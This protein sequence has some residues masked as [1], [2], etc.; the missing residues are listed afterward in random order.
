MRW[1]GVRRFG[2]TGLGRAGLGGTGLGALVLGAVAAVVVGCSAGGGGASS[3][4][5]SPP[6]ERGTVSTSGTLS[7]QRSTVPSAGTTSAE[8]PVPEGKSSGDKLT[9]QGRAALREARRAGAREVELVVVAERGHEAEVVAAAREAGARVLAEDAAVGYAR[10][11]VPV[12]RAEAFAS[13]A[14]VR[15]VDVDQPVEHR[16]PEP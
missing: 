10:L 2:G 12:E 1:C 6:Q 3:P 8:A 14:G 5:P 13:L 15:R 9:E 11:A 16:L 7:P 4:P